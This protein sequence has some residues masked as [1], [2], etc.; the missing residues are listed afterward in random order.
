MLARSNSSIRS[1]PRSASPT[2]SSVYSAYN[3]GPT[4]STTSTRFSQVVD[5]LQKRMADWKGHSLQE[6]GQL[7]LYDYINVRKDTASREFLVYV[8]LS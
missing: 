2:P 3:F 1:A 7:K 8:S 4:N 5:D 6:F